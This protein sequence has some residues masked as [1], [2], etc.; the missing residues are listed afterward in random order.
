MLSGGAMTLLEHIKTSGLGI[1]LE[2]GPARDELRRLAAKFDYEFDEVR[3]HAL[4][5]G[6]S[7]G[8]FAGL[9]REPMN[10]KDHSEAM[11][12]RAVAD[13]R[14]PRRNRTEDNEAVKRRRL[15]PLDISEFCKLDIKPREMM[16]GPIIPE[17]GLAMCYSPRGMGKTRLSTGCGLAASTATQFLKWKAPKPRRVLLLDGE[18]PAPAL[19]ELWQTTLASAP[20]KPAP[21]MFQIISSDLLEDI[22]IGNLAD[23][24]TQ[25]EIDELVTQEGTELLMLDNLSSLTSVLRDN[26][27]G[28]WQ[29][30]KAWLLKLRRRGI[31]CFLFHH[32]GKGGDQRGTS[33]REDVL[34]TVISLRHPSDYRQDEGCRFEVH[35]TK[36]RGFHGPDANPFEARQH[37]TTAGY[38]WTMREIDDVNQARVAALH[39][40]G[41]SVRDIADETGIPKSTVQR[42]VKKLSGEVGDASA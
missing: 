18:M 32:A 35:F 24:K 33:A 40:D 42:T 23:P 4:A 29:T 27:E 10:G 34:D 30:M 38:E 21:G 15:K 31:S 1:I 22:G 13:K 11:P 3:A 25:V 26:D 16:L 20:I 2:E 14:P 12:I 6:M 17:K 36:H 9:V 41:L 28:S 8:E 5:R 7:P 37:T 19:Q 39:S